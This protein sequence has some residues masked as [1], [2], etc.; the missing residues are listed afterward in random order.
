MRTPALFDLTGRAA[1]VTGGGRG[2]G[3]HISIG[4]A[5]AGAHVFLASRNLEHC[6]EVAEKI[7]AEG[8]RATALRAD[9]SK[10]DEID[11]LVG[12]VLDRTDRLHTLVNNAGIVWAAPLLEYPMEGWDRVFDLNVRGVFYLSQQVARHMKERGGGSI[13]HISSISAFR[14]GSDEQEPVVAY[15]ASKGAVTSL[16]TDMAVKLAPH[17][18]RVNAIAPGPFLTSMMDHVR[19]DPSALEA[20][21]RQVP[22]RRSAGE[23][24]IKGAVVFLASDAS[25]FVTGHTLVVDGGMLAASPAI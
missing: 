22:Q 25:A 2:I 11:A 19:H 17:Q 5:E 3:R 18:I 24:D 20:F 12:E 9:V 13:V 1:L 8:G 10:L 16:T 4:L 14:S 7:E 21:N 23:D 6:Q 15:N